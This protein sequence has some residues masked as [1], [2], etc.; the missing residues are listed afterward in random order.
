MNLFGIQ[1]KQVDRVRT[2]KAI[3]ETEDGKRVLYDLMKQHHV[4]GALPA[5][6]AH[7]IFRAEGE[8]NVV[9]RIMSI[10]NI[11]PML[12]EQKIKQGLQNEA[13]YN[14]E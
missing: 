12:F 3:F 14:Q 6:D 11:D 1:K 10:L 13:I 4:L 2:Y 9:L 8:R 7:E 5:K